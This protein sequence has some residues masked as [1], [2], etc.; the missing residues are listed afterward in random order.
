[1]QQESR[2]NINPL[3]TVEEQSL[4]YGFVS[5]SEEEKLREDIFRSDMEKLQLFSQMLRRN[6]LL[7][8]AIIIHK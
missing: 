2:K 3:N 8:K 1:M 5:K 6:T 7:K 4:Q